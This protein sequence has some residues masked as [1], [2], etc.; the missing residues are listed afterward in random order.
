[1]YFNSHVNNTYFATSSVVCLNIQ[2]LFSFSVIL[3]HV[4]IM[5]CV[6]LVLF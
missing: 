3:M 5:S 1:M 6:D 2:I 4:R